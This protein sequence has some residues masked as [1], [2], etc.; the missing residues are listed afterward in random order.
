MTFLYELDR[1]TWPKFKRPYSDYL[2]KF[3]ALLSTD[4][5]KLI[6]FSDDSR[7]KQIIDEVQNPRVIWEERPLNAWSCLSQRNRSLTKHALD[8]KR[9]RYSVPEFFS[10]EYI[11]L[12]LSKTDAILYAL[13]HYHLMTETLFWIDASFLCYPD[14]W[15]IKWTHASKLHF[16]QIDAVAKS[17]EINLNTPTVHFAGT[18]WGG[19]T[20]VMKWFCEE[21]QRKNTELLKNNLC[22]NDQQL[23]SIVSREHPDRFW[24]YKSYTMLFPLPLPIYGHLHFLTSQQFDVY[25]IFQDE[26]TSA[27][28]YSGTFIVSSILIALF[29]FVLLRRLKT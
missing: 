1:S 8:K 27:P 25:K 15:E 5:P 18:L 10:E 28:H 13:E 16:L 7:V 20:S 21:V 17:S 24:S 19:N 11:C 26:K 23:F 2:K 14:S 12:Q 9:G 3:K 29:L 4:I 22:A 6:V